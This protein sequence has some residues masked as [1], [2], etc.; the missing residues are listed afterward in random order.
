LGLF[1]ESI[2]AD[3]FGYRKLIFGS[4]FLM[5]AFLFIPFFAQNIQTYVATELLQG[6]PGV[7]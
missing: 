3:Y 6:I 2:L 4:L 5:N 7:S 1:L